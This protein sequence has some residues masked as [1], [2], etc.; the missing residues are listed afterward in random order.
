MY[1]SKRYGMEEHNF[2][3]KEIF[4][5]LKLQVVEEIYLTESMSKYWVLTG[6]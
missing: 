5:F 2:K 1:T 4:L 6:I 3:C